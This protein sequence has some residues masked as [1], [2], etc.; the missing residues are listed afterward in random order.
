MHSS[1]FSKPQ[2]WLRWGFT[3]NSHESLCS[4]VVD[5]MGEKVDNFFILV[6]LGSPGRLL[7][8]F[9]RSV[10]R[11][12][13]SVSGI[14]DDAVT[15]AIEEVG[16]TTFAAKEVAS[17]TFAITWCKMGTVG[18]TR[19]FGCLA[20]KDGRT[21]CDLWAVF[22]LLFLCRVS[23]HALLLPGLC[24]FQKFGSPFIPTLISLSHIE[25]CTQLLLMTRLSLVL[26]LAMPLASSWIL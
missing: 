25:H 6:G 3:I 4:I 21:G 26:V 7:I 18:G 22:S 5:K 24:C 2:K 20:K 17:M 12:L 13:T 1:D 10:S 14:Q 19:S 8:M 9:S 11:V 16:S 23:W 15:L